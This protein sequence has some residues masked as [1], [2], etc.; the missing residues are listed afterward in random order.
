MTTNLKNKAYQIIKERIMSCDYKPNTFL[1]EAD[2]IPLYA[3][4]STN[5]SRKA[6]SRSF[7]KKGLW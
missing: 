4:H 7:P 5:W 3:K 1:N 2:L 6:L